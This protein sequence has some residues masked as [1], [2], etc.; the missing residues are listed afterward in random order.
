[1]KLKI[2]YVA[3]PYIAQNAWAV[4]QNVRRAEEAGLFVAECG[5]M[6]LIPHTNTRF[7]HGLLTE[8][9]WYA[10][11]MELLKRSDGVLFIDGWKDSKGAVSEFKAARN[12]R[13]EIWMQSS[14]SVDGYGLYNVEL[15]TIKG[16]KSF[17]EWCKE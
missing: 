8:E 9:F 2:V 11:T 4:E 5:A 15:D 14:T 12:L 3:G 17:V 1:M 7:F 13:K 10:G 6:P 16:L